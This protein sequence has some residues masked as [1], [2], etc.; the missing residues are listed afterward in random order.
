MLSTVLSAKVSGAGSTAAHETLIDA[1]T[2][3]KNSRDSAKNWSGFNKRMGG[4]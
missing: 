1:S 3:H 2:T 4:L